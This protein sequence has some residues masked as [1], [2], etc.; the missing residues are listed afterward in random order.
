MHKWDPKWPGAVHKALRQALVDG[1][2]RTGQP[3]KIIASGLDRFHVIVI[4]L[5][6]EG[7]TYYGLRWDT[8]VSPTGMQCD[9]PDEIAGE[10]AWLCI[11]EPQGATKESI[12]RVKSSNDILWLGTIPRPEV[13]TNINQVPSEW[14]WKQQ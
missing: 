11:F 8:R 3:F 4:F 5:H 1:I 14:F 7:P 10:I 13:I 2:E 9:E 12:E 6:L